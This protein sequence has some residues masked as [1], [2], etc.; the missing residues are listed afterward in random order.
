VE[1]RN[2]SGDDRGWRTPANLFIAL[3]IVLTAA[4]IGIQV[5]RRTESTRAASAIARSTTT[6]TTTTTRPGHEGVVA[7][8]GDMVCPAGVPMTFDAC[9]QGPIS[10]LVV[11][12]PRVDYFIALGDLQYQNG[13]LGEFQTAYEPSYGR[14]KA[15]TKPVA[16]NNEY[17]TP[18]A[19]GYFDY[20]G[21]T[22][23]E[24]GKGYYSFDIGTTWHV[25]ALNG[26][27]DVVACEPGSEQERWL[28][29]DLATHPQPCTL[30]FWHQPRF[31]S[32]AEHGSDP[33]VG[34]FWNALQDHGAEIVVN[35]HEHNYERF[36][37]QLAD[38]TPSPTGIREFIAGTGGRSIHRF[39]RD[40]Q[41][42]ANS[43]ARLQTFG[44]L[45]LVLDER[46]YDW[47]FVN[48]GGIVLD[49]GTGT[50]H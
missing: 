33:S 29:T 28:R 6:S 7:A 47:Q 37:P 3:L 32:G 48:E 40:S 19:S 10:D 15:K 42:I 39:L 34:P 30:A 18:G 14:V 44:I 46:S 9:R 13:A 35:G 5:L 38:A 21:A 20:F 4:L 26:N 16:G 49:Q 23:G 27:C 45:E 12:N 22:A 11:N 36:E 43:A 1:R 24:R 25:V 8:V 17:D 31:S 2:W 41:P 50:C